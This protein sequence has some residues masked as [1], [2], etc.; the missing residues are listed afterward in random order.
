MTLLPFHRRDLF[1]ISLMVFGFSAGASPDPG[2]QLWGVDYGGATDPALAR[3]YNLLVLGPGFNRPLAPLRGKGAKLLGYISLGEVHMDRP[4]APALAKAGALGDPNPN[5]RDARYADLRH[6]AWQAMVLDELVPAILRKGYD[7]IFMDTLDNAE[8]LERQKPGMLASAAELVRAIRKRFPGT[9]IMMNR[10]Y[11]ILPK[12]VSHIDIILAEAMAS[13]WNFAGKHYEMTSADDWEWQ[14]VQ[15][16]AAR[17]AN[18]GLNPM[19]LDYWDP[20]DQATIAALY[21]RERAAGFQPYVSTLAL[22]RL[23]PEPRS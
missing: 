23:I 16:N 20:A 13:R 18:P 21:A 3:R 14:A 5:W 9:T 1:A 7:G 15:L 22:D 6:P 8:A 10:G 4:F 11:A 12:V 2:P 19:T 17:A